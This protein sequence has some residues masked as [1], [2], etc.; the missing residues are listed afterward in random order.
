MA[1]S[2]PHERFSALD[3]ETFQQMA[4][5]QSLSPHERSGFPDELRDG[6]ESAILTDIAAKLPA[7]SG[8]NATVVDI[9]CGANPLTDALV[10][11]C[12]NRGHRLTLVDG[13]DVLSHHRET[14]IVTLAAGRFPD[15]PSLLADLEERC[16]AVIAYSVLQYAFADVGVYAFA[17]A[18]LRLLAPRGRLLLG[19][20]PNASMRRRFLASDAGRQHHRAYTGS[21]EDPPAT[22]PTLPTGEIDDGAVSGLLAR[23][24]DA[25]FHAWV[26][27]QAAGLPMSNRREDIV[28][29]RP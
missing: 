4:R 22:L 20:L 24:R 11:L 9:G 12:S 5:D 23:A 28:C 21:D 13:P 29:E 18:A 7:L 10:E 15:T 2:A 14:Q 3:Y 6:A 19:D 16:D 17:D 8:R 26:M 25:G 1:P 27:P